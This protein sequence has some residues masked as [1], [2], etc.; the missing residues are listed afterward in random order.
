MKTFHLNFFILLFISYKT[1]KYCRY[2]HMA[3]IHKYGFTDF[4]NRSNKIFLIQIR[5]SQFLKGDFCIK[6]QY[7]TFLGL[8]T[9]V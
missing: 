3:Q 8:L 1:S 5:Q 6:I 9:I 4:A 7:Q 2:I